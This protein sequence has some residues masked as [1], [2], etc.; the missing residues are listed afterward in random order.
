MIDD[1]E[2]GSYIA[3]QVV[4]SILTFV[5]SALATAA[6][7]RVVGGDVL[8]R[9]VGYGESL[10]TAFGRL[11]PIIWISIL[12]GLAILGGVFLCV[13]G[14]IWLAVMFSLATPAL[15]FEDLRGTRAMGRSRALIKDNWWRVF[16]VLVVMYLIVFVIQGLLVGGVGAAVLSDSENEVRQR[17]AADVAEIV[18]YAVSLPLLAALTAYIYFDL[19]VRKEGFDIQL[20]AERMGGAEPAAPAP[21][22]SIAGLPADEPGGGFLPPRP[23]GG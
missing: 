19:R 16:G 15:I 23:P 2:L 12:S 21:S 13:V 8:G 18:G 4:A 9:R 3:G 11:G 20:L 22:S 5:A 17:R 10:R 7:L 14:A 1:D 6:C